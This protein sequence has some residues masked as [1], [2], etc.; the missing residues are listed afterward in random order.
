MIAYSVKGRIALTLGDPV[1]PVESVSKAVQ[2]FIHYCSV[3]DWEP[4]FTAVLPEY[5]TIYHQAGLQSVCIGQEA[6]IDTSIFTLG[7]HANKTLRNSYNKILRLGYRAEVFYPPIPDNLLKVLRKISN[8]WLREKQKK[9][10]QRRR[11]KQKQIPNYRKSD[12]RRG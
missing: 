12:K 1:G 8:E 7:G 6:I 5:L 3:N 9:E 4:A 11:L 10:M 2:E